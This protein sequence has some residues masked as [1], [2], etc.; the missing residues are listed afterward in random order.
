MV[1]HGKV[2]KVFTKHRQHLT[3]IMKYVR[4]GLADAK[5]SITLQ[6]ESCDAR[7]AKRY[8]SQQ[9]VIA[10]CFN[11]VYKPEAIAV[12]RNLAYAV[13]DGL[14]I[15]FFVNNSARKAVEMFDEKGLVKR[16]QIVLSA[17]PKSQLVQA[18]RARGGTSRG[19]GKHR[20]RAGVR[21]IGGGRTLKVA[22]A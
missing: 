14:A 12:G 20:K 6:P 22:T 9:C 18:N 1:K 21:A 11:R 7:G 2:Y 8:N 4:R 15:R 10:R 3:P 13:F 17:V 5:E 19:T 16:A